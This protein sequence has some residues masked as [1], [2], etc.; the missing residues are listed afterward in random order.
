MA[1]RSKLTVSAFLAFAVATTSLACGAN[2][3]FWPRFHGPEGDNISAD[4]GLL[5]R[6]PAGGPK[7]VWTAKGIGHGFSGVT[8]ANRLIYTAGNIDGKTV[9]TALDMD[10]Q[11]RWQ[12]ENGKAW[13]TSHPGTRA[14]PTIDGDVVY[15]ESPLGE[16]VC[17]NARTGK[18]IWGLNILDKFHGENI[19]WALAESLLVDG[20]RLICCPG[21]PETAVVALDKRTGRTVW[22]SPSAAGDLIG[23]ASPTLAEYKGLRMVL[24]MTLKALIGVNADTGD[25]LFR[26]E[27][28]TKY[29]INVL[30]PLYHDGHV[31]ISSGYGTTGSVLL[32]LNVRGR[33]AA[34]SKVWGSRELDNHHGGVVLLGGYLY[35]AAH[36]FNHGKWICLDWETGKMQYAERGVGKGSLTCADGM[37]YTLS[38]GRTVGLLAPTPKG[39]RLASEFEI[40]AGGEGPTWAHP[41]V[42]GGR[43]YIRHSDFLYAYDV[44][45]R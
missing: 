32:R 7:L 28:P 37:L 39:H 41:V 18:R 15:H 44:R 34:V 12:A 5:E 40:P 27:H 26:F 16:V 10:G 30:K 3:A 4:A 14:T 21:G 36:N 19:Q 45:A 31:F 25:L 11:I 17:L 20:D 23:Y 9:V 8:L 24:T 35:G 22:R 13:T 42:C 43:L 2:S 29:D 1:L 33:K 38:E 6:W